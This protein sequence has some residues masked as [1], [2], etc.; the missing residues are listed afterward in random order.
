MCGVAEYP[1][2]NPFFSSAGG[3]STSLR[4]CPTKLPVK[5][6]IQLGQLDVPAS[7]ILKVDLAPLGCGAVC[8]S[9][10]VA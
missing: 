5:W 6:E 3:H 9:C 4:L 1:A 2:T 7:V 10:S 8:A